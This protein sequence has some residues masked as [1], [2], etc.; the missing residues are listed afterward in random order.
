MKLFIA[1]ILS[2]N[3]FCHELEYQNYLILQKS[4]VEGN[5]DQGLK[6]WKTMCKKE[7][8][9]YAKDYKYDDCDKNISTISGLRDSFKLLSEIYIK[10]GKSL[11]NS[12]LKIVKCPMAKARWIQKG[13]SVKNPYYG[14]KMLTCGEIES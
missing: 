14:K 8:G 1:L 13:S 11:E 7:L 5:L 12:D 4:L 2:F 10:N 6:S 9:H 3:V